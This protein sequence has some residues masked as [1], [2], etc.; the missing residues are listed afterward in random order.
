ML[1]QANAELE[2]FSSSVSHDL[3]APLRHIYGYAEFLHE[4]F[5]PVLGES[6]GRT[7]DQIR[8]A[9]AQ[10]GTLIDDLLSFSRMSRKEMHKTPVKMDELAREVIAEMEADTRGRTIEWTVDMLPE[11]LVDRSL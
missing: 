7:L 1:E 9:A 11:V 3:R 2:A 4:D 10:M 6:G 5:A 8:K